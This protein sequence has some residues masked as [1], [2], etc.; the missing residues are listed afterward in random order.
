MKSVTLAGVGISLILFSFS[1]TSL[2]AQG[3]FQ[4]TYYGTL[5]T[6]VI[7]IVLGIAAD[8][9]FVIVDAWR[10]SKHIPECEGKINQRLAYTF[11]RAARAT[12]VTSSTTS[13][14]FLANAFS[15][16]MPIA[17]FG[18]YAAIIVSVNFFLIIIMYPPMIV[19]YDKKLE[20]KWICCGEKP[21]Q[22]QGEQQE[23]GKLEKFFDTTWN[24]FVH[25]FRWVI[26][27]IFFI[28]TVVAA[29]FAAQLEPVSEA[30]E[31]LPT[32][33]PIQQFFSTSSKQFLGAGQ[34]TINVDL[35]WGMKGINKEGTSM[36]NATNIGTLM[37]QD[38]FDL[39]PADAQ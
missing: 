21:I 24:T 22:V 27:I 3:V 17:S 1:V 20:G 30:E 34:T 31:Y 37:W 9:I 23:M 38:D 4:S 11:R 32:D 10:Q 25:K 7:F 39:S 12:A 28:W 36:W 16:M 13:V 35:Y 26:L 18:I 15:P 14:A 29:I 6:L 8:D 2:I 19:W 5:H 33:H